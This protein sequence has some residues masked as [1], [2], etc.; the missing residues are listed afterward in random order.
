MTD[1][2]T[3]P[4]QRRN[5][6]LLWVLIVLGGA[7]LLCGLYVGGLY[8]A[9]LRATAEPAAVAR[10]FLEATG[11][12][13]FETAFGLLSPGLQAEFTTADG[14]GTE[15]QARRIAPVEIAS[16]DR[17]TIE[18]EVVTV[19]APVTFADGALQTATITL[20]FNQERTAWVVTGFRFD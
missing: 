7:V 4:Q 6:F 12:S 20:E 19:S 3:Q 10:T 15:M 1:E 14:F 2:T 16:F 13:D 17:P 18:G 9:V 8:Y 5:R 11:D